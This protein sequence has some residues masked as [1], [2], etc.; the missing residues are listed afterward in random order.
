MVA[1]GSKTRNVSDSSW[2]KFTPRANGHIPPPLASS[3]PPK[4][5]KQQQQQSNAS[6]NGFGTS[7]PKKR[8]A[9]G[10]VDH[11]PGGFGGAFQQGN[12]RKKRVAYMMEEDED[13]E[14]DRGHSL[15][16]NGVAHA[17]TSGLATTNGK[18]EGKG[19][20][21]D[22]KKFAELQEQRKNLPIAKGEFIVEF[23]STA[24][25]TPYL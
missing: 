16:S 19:G 7:S 15:L 2:S 22:T 12:L 13:E 24:I 10:D 23:R 21:K 14:E 18:K 17:S 8:K 9:E 25:L 1:F 20:M 6:V 3:T 11:Y 5:N 4:K